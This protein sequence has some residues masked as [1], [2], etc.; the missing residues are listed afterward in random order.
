MIGGWAPVSE[1]SRISA[2][3]YAGT[4]A[5]MLVEFN[6]ARGKPLQHLAMDFYTYRTGMLI[7]VAYYMGGNVK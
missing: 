2:I 7:D 5:G 6:G 4:D 1:R 3:I